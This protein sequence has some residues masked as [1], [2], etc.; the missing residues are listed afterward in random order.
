MKCVILVLALCTQGQ[1]V[2]SQC[3]AS[4]QCRVNDQCPDFLLKNERLKTLTKGTTQHTSLK[5]SL[6]ALVCNRAE[7]KVCCK[8]ETEISGS[9][10]PTEPH[11]FP[12]MVRLEIQVIDSAPGEKHGISQVFV[13]STYK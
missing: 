2:V 4:L 9:I 5:A 6:R 13:Y 12:F 1:P 10:G 8:T 7:R 3:P 11:E